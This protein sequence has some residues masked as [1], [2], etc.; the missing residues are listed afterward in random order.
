MQDILHLMK[1]E[2]PPL[3]PILRSRAQAEVV[4]LVLWSAPQEFSLTELADRTGVSLATVQREIERCEQADIVKSRRIGNVRLVSASVSRD[5]QLLC[6]L[7]LRSFGPK[8]VVAD[9]FLKVAGVKQIII[10]GSWAARYSG[11]E[12]NA[13]GDI[14]LLVLGDAK[15]SEVSKACTRV[16]RRIDREVNAV[17]RPLTWLTK[18]SNDPLKKEVQRR[19]YII[20]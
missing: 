17:N 14:D 10:F 1:P 13:P 15:F 3:L 9:E 4:G 16:S 12:G 11:V 5:A 8:Y 2:S 7:L 18:A 20:V 19:P 6:E